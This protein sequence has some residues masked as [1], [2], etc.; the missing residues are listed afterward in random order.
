MEVVA[1]LPMKGHSER[2]P[3][4]NLRSIAGKPLYHWVTE[5]LLAAKTVNRVVVDTDS[6]AIAEHV[7]GSFPNVEIHRRPSHLHG[8]LVAM[9]D[10][11]AY[12]AH[13]IEG[14]VFL[15]TH[16][17]N[18][19]LRAETIDAAVTAFLEEG[20]HDSLMSVTP[21][22]TRFYFSDGR[23]VNHD[24]DV[25]LRTQDLSPLLEENSNLYIAARELILRTG[26]RVGSKPLLF[27]IERREA[28]DIDEELDFMVAEFLLRHTDG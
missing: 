3:G 28:T 6:D 13:A 24:P 7:F 23:P 9:H 10:I 1:L 15:Q 4:K 26:R 18:P 17:T 20:S 19:L 5:A 2:V 8:D 22:Q 25:L 16:S 14:D 11:V 12:L 27:P 21:W